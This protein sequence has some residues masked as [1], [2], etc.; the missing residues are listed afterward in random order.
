MRNVTIRHS[1][2][3]SPEG[4]DEVS[5][6]LRYESD[7]VSEENFLTFVPHTWGKKGRREKKEREGRKSNE[8]RNAGEKGKRGEEKE[9]KKRGVGG[10][11]WK[12]FRRKMCE[13]ER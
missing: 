8:Q 6:Q 12:K 7:S 10:C 5:G 4:S 13:R 3:H 1:I 11:V 9:E 2:T